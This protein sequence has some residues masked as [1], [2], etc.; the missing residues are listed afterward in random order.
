MNE[1]EQCPEY[2][3]AAGYSGELCNSKTVLLGVSYF[4]TNMLN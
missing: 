3:C 1:E 4:N 2:H